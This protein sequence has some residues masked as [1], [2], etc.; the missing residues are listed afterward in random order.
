VNLAHAGCVVV[1]LALSSSCRLAEG[2]FHEQYAKFRSV[3]VGMTEKQVREKLG[4]PTFVHQKGVRPDTYCVPGWACERREVQ[5]RLLIY[6]GVEPIAYVF[7]NS[8]GSV[9]HVF[10]GGS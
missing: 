8:N 4:E 5:H 3:S 9:E 6:R 10:V 1:L 2:P 7:F